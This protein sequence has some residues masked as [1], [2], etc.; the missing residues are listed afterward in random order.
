MARVIVYT[1]SMCPF[2]VRAKRLLYERGISYDE[3]NVEDDPGLREEMVG[4][5]GGRRTVPQIFIDGTH[6]GGYAEL[7]LLAD[8]GGLTTLP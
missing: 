8:R 4:R 1:A 2:C 7:Q 3:I 5:A 6:V